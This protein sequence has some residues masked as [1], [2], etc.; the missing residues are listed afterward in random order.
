MKLALLLT[1][2]VLFVVSGCAHPVNVVPALDEAE[3]QTLTCKD[4][5]RESDRLN[6]LLNQLRHGNEPLFGNDPARVQEAEQAAQMRLNQIRE[7]S[8]QKL[9]VF[10]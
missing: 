7:L 4:I 1:V 8:V 9:C 2:P 6:I 10:G 3:K 5:G